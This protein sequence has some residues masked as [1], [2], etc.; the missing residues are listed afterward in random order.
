MT[1]KRGRGQGGGCVVWGGGM[2]ER[3]K[4]D[5]NSGRESWIEEETIWSVFAVSLV[6]RVSINL[7][8][9][10]CPYNPYTML[11]GESWET[12]RSREGG[13][14]KDED[15]GGCEFL[16]R[17]KGRFRFTACNDSRGGFNW[18]IS[19]A[20]SSGSL[21]IHQSEWS[22]LE[23]RY[24]QYLGMVVRMWIWLVSVKDAMKDGWKEKCLNY[25]TSHFPHDPNEGKPWSL[26]RDWDA[27]QYLR[28][29]R[30]VKGHGCTPC[31]G[32]WNCG[33]METDGRT[34]IDVLLWNLAAMSSRKRT[35]INPGAWW[36]TDVRLIIKWL[37]CVNSLFERH[38]WD[39]WPLTSERSKGQKAHAPAPLLLSPSC[40]AAL[41]ATSSSRLIILQDSLG[42]MWQS[43]WQ[44]WGGGS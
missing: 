17:A 44:Q 40:Q 1:S 35:M 11:R 32:G 29:G 4:E 28:K 31:R 19:L 26:N 43:I 20:D 15:V 8:T 41:R 10:C 22:V 34:S 36:P 12:K 39:G 42:G 5:R 9:Q 30:E 23:H 27:K 37:G 24:F 13:W 14:D 16:L 38:R 3:R 18:F 7:T 33:W 6:I 21:W 2:K 25:T